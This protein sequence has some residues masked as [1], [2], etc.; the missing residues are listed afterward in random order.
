MSDTLIL[1]R[2]ANG[3]YPERVE[4][5]TTAL[6]RFFQNIFDHLN[7]PHISRVH[8][9]RVCRR[10]QHLTTSYTTLDDDQLNEAIRLLRRDL[11][12]NGLRSDL[13]A[14]AFAIIREIAGRTLGMRHHICQLHGAWV[15]LNGMIAE[16]QTGEGKT[17]T[18]TLAAGTAALAGVPVHVITVNDYLTERDAESM[19]PVYQRLG[20]SVG[21]VI[22]GMS[23]DAKRQAYACDI[24]YCTNKELV[25]DYLKDRITLGN[26]KSELRL[27]MEKLYGSSSRAQ[28]LLLRGLCYAIVD[29]ADSVL[30]DEART[31]LII[32][33]QAENMDEANMIHQAL[34]L[35]DELVHGIHFRIHDT[36]RRV[37]LTES[38]KQTLPEL[39]HELG[40]LWHGT[41]RREELMTQALTAR[42]LFNRDEH[43]IVEEGKVVII[44]EYTGR[45]MPD[46][47]W[48]RGIHQLIEAKE[49]CELT[50]QREPLARISYQRFFRRYL[51]LSGMTGTAKEVKRELQSVYRLKA[52]SIAP[53]KKVQRRYKGDRVYL[54][55]DEKWREL[56]KCVKQ[57][58]QQGR[59]VLI[60]T[61]T[62]AIS[63][64]VSVELNKAG[65][66][67]RLLNARQD[68][69][70]NH[71]IAE[72]GTKG[73]IT[74]ATNMAGRGTDI[75]INDAINKAGGLH[76]ILTERHD[77]RRIDR[78]LIGRCARQGNHGSYQ[79]ILSWE[80]AIMDLQRKSILAKIIKSKHM[81]STRVGQWLARRML[82]K[83]QRAIENT[84]FKMRVELLKA[85]RQLGDLLSFSG[86]LE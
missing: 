65:L 57:H 12:S 31:P 55:Q 67:H 72:A 63:E 49:G 62:L 82:N 48:S 29:E 17:L 79:A 51:H 50:M 69:D 68:A 36:E 34:S 46:R 58:H 33:G 5:K 23:R 73:R 11:T 2:I 74:I 25:F 38:G 45:S 78:Q 84:H 85:D 52:V 41:I 54:T 60:G 86:Y 10:I 30:V 28:R 59:P 44:D 19:L 71:I 4:K 16:M 21:V 47:S 40:G 39:T 1:P 7:H 9:N 37:E 75:H 64:I 3:I 22:A 20:L 61:R 66:P 24:T 42:Y 80:D 76:V 8:F 81:V 53:H 56:V 26:H 18:A 6:D 15:M 35:T 70:E 43:Y 83:G 27:A 77:A 14:H 13:V 32:S